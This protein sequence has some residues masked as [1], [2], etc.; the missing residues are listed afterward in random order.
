METVGKRRCAFQHRE[1]TAI[2]KLWKIKWLWKGGRAF[3]RP[4]KPKLRFAREE[5]RLGEVSSLLPNGT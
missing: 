5:A 1:C 3:L 2:R 4:G